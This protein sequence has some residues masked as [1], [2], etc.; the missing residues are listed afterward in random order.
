MNS[1]KKE[2]KPRG[3]GRWPHPVGDNQ[4]FQNGNEACTSGIIDRV[5]QYIKFYHIVY[6]ATYFKDINAR[7]ITIQQYAP[8]QMQIKL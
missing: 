6:M 7:R 4:I 1:G 3:I 2:E 8:A 5:Y